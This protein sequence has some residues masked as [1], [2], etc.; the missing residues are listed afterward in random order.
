MSG[1]EHQCERVG[2]VPIRRAVRYRSTPSSRRSSVVIVVGGF[3]FAAA[4]SHVGRG[5]DT[6]VFSSTKMQGLF[7]STKMLMTNSDLRSPISDFR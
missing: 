2:V 5:T 6:L 7:P 3:G 1:D 4:S